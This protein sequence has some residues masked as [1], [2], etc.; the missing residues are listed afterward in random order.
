MR[1]ERLRRTSPPVLHRYPGNPIL[2]A[3]QVP[4]PSKLVYNPGVAKWE[5][6]Y[7]M[8]FRSDKGW[9]EQ[10][11][12]APIFEIGLAFSDDGIRWESEL[13]PV[14]SG[15]NDEDLGYYDP[16]ICPVEDRMLACYA[17]HTAHGWRGV[18]AET[19]D[20]RQ[21]EELHRTVPDNRNIVVF[22]EKIDGKY[23]RLERPFPILSRQ[24]REL[25]DIWI[26]NSPDLRYW[27]ESELLFTTEHVSDF[28]NVKVAAG[29]APIKTE[30]GW[31]VII[32]TVWED[33]TAGKNGWEDSWKRTYCAA[34]M[35]LDLDD[36]R[37]VIGYSREPLFEP[38]A[39]YETKM[40]F[41]YNVVF[42]SGLIVEPDQT[43][44]L[45]YGAADSFVALATGNLSDL[46]AECKPA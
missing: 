22:P 19:L 23:W 44:K 31:L 4:F 17:E 32:H 37:K 18:I 35:L 6:R 39:D 40:G 1:P 2:T 15:W 30:A 13:E 41:R 29:P 8:L 34:A 42:P 16:R 7:V 36:P 24:S 10:D 26:S 27:G 3:D 45:Y 33:E 21:F 46:I 20:F 43:V 14:L 38:E 9:D 5:D 11:K 12:K 25:H 28:C